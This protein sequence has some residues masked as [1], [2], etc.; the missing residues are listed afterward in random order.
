VRHAI[1]KAVVSQILWRTGYRVNISMA[2]V[3]EFLK[4]LHSQ[5]RGGK[6]QDYDGASGV[7]IANAN[8]KG[9]GAGWTYKFKIGIRD[10]PSP[11][12]FNIGPSPAEVK[13]LT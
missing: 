5:S 1:A 9:D 12:K 4:K 6:H 13:A 11:N 8:Y 7:V 2:S 10:V 3:V